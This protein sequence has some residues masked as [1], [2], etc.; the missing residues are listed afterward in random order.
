MLTN[1]WITPQTPERVVVLGSRGFLGAA[2]VDRL[3]SDGVPVLALS[4]ADLDLTAAGAGEAL[5]GRLAPGDALVMFSALTPDRGRDI[6]A[7]MRNLEM[8]RAVCQAL[9]RQ[10]VAHVVYISSD[11]VYPFAAGV[12]DEQTLP[13][14]G[15]LYG[16]MHRTR[17]VMM[18]AT[19]KGPL[20]ILRPTLVYGAKD[21]HNSYGPNRFRRQAA[22]DGRIVLGG[23]GEETRD[24]ILVDDAVA[25]IRRVLI[26]RS[27]GVLNLATG[28]SVSFGDLARLVA[29]QFSPA[30]TVAFTPRTTPAT[31][32][33]FDVTV[34]RQAFP[35]FVFT[36]LEDGLARV[37]Q[38]AGPGK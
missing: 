7:L 33:S 19:V 32:R 11:A 30:A 35:D 37:H 3:R 23:E 29:A 12:V 38:A 13:A 4:S 5:A 6:G 10:A 20:A 34:C 8:C 18:Q 22:A 9:E 24:H 1:T 15:D 21:T 31:H 26:H 2:A 36:T 14:P 28:R 16:C 25:L 27:A 17:E